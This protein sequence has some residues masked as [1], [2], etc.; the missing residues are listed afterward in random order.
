MN[1]KKVVVLV[2]GLCCISI[3]VWLFQTIMPGIM[4]DLK[5]E[6]YS[7]SSWQKVDFFGEGEFSVPSEWTF[8]VK[9]DEIEFMDSSG[10]SILYVYPDSSMEPAHYPEIIDASIITRIKTGMGTG[11]FRPASNARLYAYSDQEL[12]FYSATLYNRTIFSGMI[13]EDYFGSFNARRN[14]IELEVFLNIVRSYT[15]N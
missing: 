3:I 15:P 13:G 1:K 5:I 7:N 14:D 10:V 6:P 9:N 11:L 8:T 12:D 4:I 2:A